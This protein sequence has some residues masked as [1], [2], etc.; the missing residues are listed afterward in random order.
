MITKSEV[1]SMPLQNTC[2]LKEIKKM[3]IHQPLGQCDH[4]HYDVKQDMKIYKHHWC[5]WYHIDLN[6]K[7]SP[8]SLISWLCKKKKKIILHAQSFK[9][10]A[11]YKQV[12]E[13][14]NQV[15]QNPL[16]PL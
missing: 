14:E 10:T 3:H 16:H 13:P 7:C 5:K 2:I 4:E 12:L 9:A 6:A 1:W 11:L 8:K 15:E